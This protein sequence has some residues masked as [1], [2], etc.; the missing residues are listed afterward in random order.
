MPKDKNNS[1]DNKKRKSRQNSWTNDEA[2]ADGTKNGKIKQRAEFSA[3]KSAPVINIPMNNNTRGLYTDEL[4]PKL[5]ELASKGLNNLQIAEALC[6]G[7]KTFYEW[8]AR[9]PQFALSLAK[10][11]GV[12]DIQVENALFANCTGFIYQEQQ[13]TPQGKV[14]TVNKFK[15]GDTKAQIFWVTNRKNERW[16]NKVETTIGI[17]QDISQM[18]FAIKR[19]EE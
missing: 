14:V 6:I 11:R 4:L 17:T 1:K 5:E 8:R 2:N 7:E 16:K 12:A 3:G 9:Y 15:T 10:Y 19:R 18:V 13:A